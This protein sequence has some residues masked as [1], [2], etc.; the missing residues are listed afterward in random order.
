MKKYWYWWID[1][2]TRPSTFL[3][4]LF[5]FIGYEIYSRPQIFDKFLENIVNNEG[6]ITLIIGT[7]SG[8]LVRH[9]SY[10]DKSNKDN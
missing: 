8:Y 7:I 3:G 5:L 10:E 2:I 4:F 1:N 6:L 9:K